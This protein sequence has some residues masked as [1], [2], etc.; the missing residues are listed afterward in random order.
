MPRATVTSKGQITIP[1]SVRDRLHLDS[2]STVDFIVEAPGRVVLRPLAGSVRDLGGILR[3]SGARAVSVEEIDE[4][5]AADRA[6]DD[7]RIR[8]GR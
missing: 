4:A 3:R 7:E 5:I 2:G 8:A 1:K 6:V